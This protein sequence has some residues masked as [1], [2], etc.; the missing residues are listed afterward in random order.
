MFMGFIIG[1]AGYGI[2][3]LL[4]GGFLWWKGRER[5]TGMSKMA[6]SF[7]IGGIF[8]IVWGLLFNSLFGFTLLPKTV[9]PNP[10]NDMWILAGIKVPCVLIIAM[11]IGVVQLCVG[12]LC[13]AVQEWRRG[14]IL[15]GICEGVIWAIFSVG[16]GLAIIGFVEE[17][18]LPILATVGGITAG[19][20]LLLAMLTAGR[21]EKFF[22]IFTKKR[23]STL[24]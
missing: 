15:D 6:A 11:L 19:G 13:K 20:S 14:G 3:M 16:V 17:A 18:E 1:D 2:L 23:K 5:P 22:G 4:G 7:A 12:Y 21:K 10:Q 24:F 8:A 9:M